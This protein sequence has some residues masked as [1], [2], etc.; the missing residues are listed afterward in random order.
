MIPTEV[1]LMASAF[2]ATWW[3]SA[4]K[5]RRQVECYARRSGF[6]GDDVGFVIF[7][8]GG[9]TLADGADIRVVQKGN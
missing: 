4:W 6:P 1:P 7:A 5:Y 3:N 8:T 2:S 9:H